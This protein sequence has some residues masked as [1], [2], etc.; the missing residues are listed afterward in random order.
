MLGLAYINIYNSE[1]MKVTMG[2]YNTKII[3][4][5]FKQGKNNLEKNFTL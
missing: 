4:Q 3:I 1:Q 2:Q 5:Q